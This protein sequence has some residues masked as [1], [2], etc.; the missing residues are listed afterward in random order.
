[1]RPRSRLLLRLLALTAGGLLSA[2]PAALASSTTSANWSG[3]AAHRTGVRFR[4]V[5]GE[6]RVPT[7]SCA[8]GSVG[9]SSIWVGLGGYSLNSSALEQTGS[10]ADCTRS[11]Q[12]RY[13]AWYELVPAA[14][15]SLSLG[16]RPGDLMRASVSAAAT[17]V[18]IAVS[19]LTDRRAFRRTFH[20]SQLDLT[21]A[22]WIV[23]A[24][25]ECTGAGQCFAL[26]LADF[27]QASL[28]AARATTTAGRAGAITSPWW[29]STEITLVPHSS[30]L[31]ADMADPPGEAIPSALTAGGSTFTVSYQPI[32]QPGGGSGPPGPF[33]RTR[34]SGTATA[35]LVHPIR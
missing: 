16:V 21:S 34:A 20:P 22:E 26:P 33:F 14:P 5:S 28:F 17:Q 30:R 11:G 3:Y 19:D 10:E 35:R 18:T 23:E 7:A 6:W 25:S 27:G 24:P 29:N 12:A 31:F 8:A 13:F 15:R 32:S 4:S 9:Y 2:S 1:L